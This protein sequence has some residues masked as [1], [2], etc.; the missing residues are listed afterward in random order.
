MLEGHSNVIVTSKVVVTVGKS[1]RNE[2]IVKTT[3]PGRTSA[4]GE[5]TLK[6]KKAPDAV[7]S[8]TAAYVTVSVVSLTT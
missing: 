6:S 3:S 2:L 1:V 8:V 5:S 7:V 4:G